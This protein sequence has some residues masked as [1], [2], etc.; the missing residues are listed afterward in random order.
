MIHTHLRRNAVSYLALA[1]ALSTGT[2]AYAAGSV[3]D[4]SGLTAKLAKDAVKS[5]NIKNN[6][7][8]SKDVKDGSLTAADLA[9]GSLLSFKSQSDGGT[10]SGT[11]DSGNQKPFAFTAG[12]SAYVQA[13]VD[14]AGLSC[15]NG[16]G[17]IGLYVDGAP[18]GGTGYDL[19]GSADARAITLSA[20]VTSAA[21]NHVASI[22]LDCP[23]G[24]IL[25][26]T[27]EGVHWFELGGR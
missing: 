8:K 25:T 3:A 23:S 17:K 12:G 22:G 16:G 19:P 18:V 4:G 13:N 26:P 7:I 2:A 5:K 11:P 24:N 14:Q 27:L 21:G 6:T 10:P 15:D 9:A 1:I 20:T